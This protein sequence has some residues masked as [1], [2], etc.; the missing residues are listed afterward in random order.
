MHHSAI[1]IILNGNSPLLPLPK[2][3]KNELILT[4]YSHTVKYTT[5]KENEIPLHE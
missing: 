4:N 3:K 2:Y 1:I 5:I